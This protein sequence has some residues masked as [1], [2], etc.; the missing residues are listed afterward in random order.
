MTTIIGAEI[1]KVNQDWGAMTLMGRIHAEDDDVKKRVKA[2]ILSI[3]EKAKV[4]DAL[5]E[6]VSLNQVPDQGVV[7]WR[8]TVRGTF[9]S[10]CRCLES[11]INLSKTPINPP[12]SLE[13]D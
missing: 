13:E 11:Q 6:V 9:R 8:E 1:F 5:E 2:W 7:L 10:R 4:P 12:D 3:R